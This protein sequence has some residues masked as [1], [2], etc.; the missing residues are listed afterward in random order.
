M[1]ALSAKTISPRKLVLMFGAF[2]VTCLYAQLSSAAD[3]IKGGEIYAA[4]CSACHG[5]NGVP[6]MPDAPNFARSERLMRPDVFV[7]AAIRDGKN[8]MPSYQGVLSDSEILDVVVYL[9]TLEKI[10]PVSP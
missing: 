1:I 7:A 5:S 9:R 10:G 2:L 4:H 8:A 3:T 6:V